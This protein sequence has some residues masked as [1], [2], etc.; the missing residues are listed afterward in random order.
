MGNS[1][2][3][4]AQLAGAHV[5]RPHVAR[6]SRQSLGIASSHDDQILVDNARASQ[7]NRLLLRLASKISAEIDAPILAKGGNWLAGSGVQRVKEVHHACKNPLIFPACPIS[8]PAVS[9]RAACPRISCP[10]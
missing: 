10:N 3:G 4:P 8:Q 9:Q 6:R 5:I 2:K 7:R 1:M